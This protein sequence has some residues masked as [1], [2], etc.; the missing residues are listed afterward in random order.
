MINEDETLMSRGASRRASASDIRGIVLSP[1][2]ELA[3]QIASEARALCRHTGLV[4][5]TAV[6]G[7]NRSQMLRQTQRQGCHLLV[8]TPGRLND[9]LQDPSSGIEAPNLAAMVLDEADR[10]LDVG[11][12]K[13]LQEITDNLPDSHEKQRQTMLVSATIP[14]DVIRLARSM[15]R[16]DDFEFV[17]T[18][19]QNESLTHDKVPQKIVPVTSWA[20]MF[21]TL[22]ELMDREAR[23]AAEDP[24]SPPFKA[25]VY[26]NTTAMTE[27]AG[28]IGFSRHRERISDLS[29]HCI[30]SKLSQ[31]Q[32]TRASE[33]FR[34]QRSGVLYSSD[35]TARGM[36]FPNVTH[37]IQMDVPRERESYIHRLGR[38]GRQ[39]KYGEG[40]LLLPP[41]SVRNARTLLKGLPLQQDNTLE[42]SSV[43]IADTAALPPLHQQFQDLVRNANKRSLAEAYTVLFSSCTGGTRE[44]LSEDLHIWTTRGWGWESPPVVSRQWATKQGLDS[45]SPFMNVGEVQRYS[46]R[47]SGFGGGFDG[48]FS[49]RRGGGASGGR[50]DGGGGRGGGRSDDPFNDM[51]NNARYDRPG[52]RGD[53]RGRGGRSTSRSYF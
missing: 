5:Q 53:S 37:V 38:T 30:H 3:E 11:F 23:K 43:D 36:D 47:D 22:F 1:T 39:D 28:E 13:E 44:E 34:R 7:T 2:R 6:G 12:E 18:I 29:S 19:P 40:W 8:A 41:L 16:P 15:V 52:G 35:V 20:N 21:P 45:R 26:F 25:I 17:Q 51:R 24:D 9:L 31:M 48:G 32:R 49:S 33:A 50:F 14:D 10:M 42:A 27:L 46:N 4:V